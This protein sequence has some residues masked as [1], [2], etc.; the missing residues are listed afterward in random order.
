[1]IGLQPPWT[2]QPGFVKGRVQSAWPVIA[3]MPMSRSRQCHQSQCRSKWTQPTLA[4]HPAR[5]GPRT[6]NRANQHQPRVQ[7]GRML[8]TLFQGICEICESRELC[9]ET[10]SRSNHPEHIKG[11]VPSRY[12][13]SGLSLFRKEVFEGST[14][15]PSPT[16]RPSRPSP[17]TTAPNE[18]GRWAL[19]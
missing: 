17:G 13:S 19:S 11:R 16:R 9:R 7:K 6:S 14:R 5:R 10:H 18:T 4:L 15:S 2:L 3:L 1:M 12:I 8:R